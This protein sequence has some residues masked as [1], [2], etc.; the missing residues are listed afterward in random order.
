MNTNKHEI[1]KRSQILLVKTLGSPSATS[2]N[3]G[4]GRFIN[5]SHVTSFG[6]RHVRLRPSLLRFLSWMSPRGRRRLQ[7]AEFLL[8]R[9]N[10]VKY[11]L[12]SRLSLISG[13]DAQLRSFEDADR[14][15]FPGGRNEL[16]G[17]WI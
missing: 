9:A 8:Y 10:R 12:L 2:L 6:I 7:S 3:V 15:G 11:L 16:S 5:E 1:T 14:R 13:E 17:D 4:I